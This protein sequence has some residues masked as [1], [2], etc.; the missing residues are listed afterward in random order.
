ML[1]Q[2]DQQR[3]G[4][5]RAIPQASRKRLSRAAI[6]VVDRAESA[7]LTLPGALYGLRPCSSPL[8]YTYAY[9]ISVLKRNTVATISNT[10]LQMVDFLVT[11][12]DPKADP[13]LHGRDCRRAA[14]TFYHGKN[15]GD[16]GGER[17]TERTARK[18]STGNRQVTTAWYPTVCRNPPQG[19]AAPIEWRAA[20]GARGERNTYRKSR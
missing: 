5:G 11:R 8:Y 1:R 4:P 18:F 14:V 2:T 3:R 10:S 19:F 13:E 12:G 17:R 9:P 6:S 7:P 15:C 16:G 20:N